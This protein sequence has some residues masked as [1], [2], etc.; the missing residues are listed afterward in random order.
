VSNGRESVVRKGS[1]VQRG[2]ITVRSRYQA[3]TSA[4]T[5][6]WKRLSTCSSEL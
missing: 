5:A 3:A 1:T 6:D 2:I 4:D